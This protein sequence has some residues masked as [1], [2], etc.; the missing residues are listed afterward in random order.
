[1]LSTQNL[2]LLGN[3]VAFL[4]IK[5]VSSGTKIAMLACKS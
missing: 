5:I 1:V 4:G 2:L 3:K